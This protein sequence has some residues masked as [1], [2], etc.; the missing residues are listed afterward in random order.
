MSEGCTERCDEDGANV[1]LRSAL[2]DKL[3]EHEVVV[4]VGDD[5]GNVVGLGEDE[6]MRIVGR[7]CWSK[8]AAKLQRGVDAGAEV[9]EVLGAR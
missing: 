1:I 3:Q 4:T 5:T 7:R 8:L 2:R 9:G 6:A